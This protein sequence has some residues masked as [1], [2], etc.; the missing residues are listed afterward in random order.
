MN[1]LTFSGTALPGTVWHLIASGIVANNANAKT[2]FFNLG[3]LNP[4]GQL[5]ITPAVSTT[6]LWW[7]DVWF[8]AFGTSLRQVGNGYTG[9]N[10]G[11]VTQT[12][13]CNFSRP[14]L[15]NPSSFIIIGCTQVAAGDVTINH[16]LFGPGVSPS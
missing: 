15:I 5:T 8:I 13:A 2:V 11:A 7:F 3:T 6:N 14:N 16:L 9:P 12:V 1:R 10:P 4:S